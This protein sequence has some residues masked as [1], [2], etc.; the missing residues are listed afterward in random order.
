MSAVTTTG[1]DTSTALSG[2]D[3]DRLRQASEILLEAR[4]TVTPVAELPEKLRPASLAEA[5]FV[6]DA[7]IEELGAI[8][9]WKVGASSPEATPMFAPMF[10]FGM[11]SDGALIANSMRRMRGVEAE[12]AFLLGRDLPTRTTAYTR[13]EVLAAIASA[14]PTIELLESAYLDPDAVDRLAMIADLQMHGGFVHGPAYAGWRNF[15]FGQENVTVTVDG[16]VRTDK[17]A[18]GFGTD[19]LQLVVWLANEGQ[20]RTGGLYAGQWITTGSWMGKTLAQPGSEV[21]VH[22]NHFGDVRCRFE[23]HEPRFP[24]TEPVVLHH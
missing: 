20:P 14:H 17:G 22:F 16:V 9:G 18:N 12:I 3:R 6:Q 1:R 13:D 5:Y 21:H 15:D 24:R 2:I 8:A 7:M 23:A 19:L 11:A 10:D 4:R